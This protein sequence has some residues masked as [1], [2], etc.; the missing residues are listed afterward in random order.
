MKKGI[1]SCKNGFTLIELLVVVAIIGVLSSVVLASLNSARI[2]ARDARRKSDIHQ[3]QLALN[4]YYSDN[5]RYPQA[6]G[7]AYDVNCYTYSTAGANWIPALSSYIAQ[8]PIDPIN[9]ISGPW[10]TGQYSYAYGNVR[11]DGR[12][13]LVA[14]LE[15]TS[16]PD[17]CQLK[18][19]IFKWTGVSWCGGYSPYIY[20]P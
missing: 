6:A 8:I 10:W 12:F 4:L 7:C 17:R 16:D 19:Y 11:S 2:K 9:N 13:D 18:Q 14:Q 1:R 15:N 20:A 3:I 5:G